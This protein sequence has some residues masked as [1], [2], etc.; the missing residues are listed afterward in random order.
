MKLN[1]TSQYALRIMEQIARNQDILH[2]G[3]SIS[4]NL[5]I[6]YK[7]LTKI[8]TMLVNANLIFSIKGR[9]GGY[10][11]AK[12]CEDIKL[13]DIL[14]AVKEIVDQKECILGIGL[15]KESKKCA[16]HD[17]WKEPKKNIIN[18]FKENS[19]KDLL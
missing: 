13:I 8:M 1:I 2:S 12:A 10:K 9:D 4:E 6:P 15:C 3:K 19:L 16:M 14:E 18:L 17:I 7:Y 5:S 11:L